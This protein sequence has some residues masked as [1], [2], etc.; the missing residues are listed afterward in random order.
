MKST[1]IRLDGFRLTRDTRAT[2]AVEFAI[3]ALALV[4]LIV[5]FVEFGRLAWTFEV[6]QESAFE[7]ARCMGLR[8]TS[9]AAGGVYNA[10]NTRNYVIS[11]ATARGVVLTAGA[12]SLSNA[13]SC[14]GVSGFSNVSINYDFITVAPLLIASLVHGYVVPASACF[15]NNS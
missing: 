15:P 3:C 6:L 2:T 8:S 13:A 4:L 9:C 5:G 7:G 14:G 12:I 11:V 10:T 1:A